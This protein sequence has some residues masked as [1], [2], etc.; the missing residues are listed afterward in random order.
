M[1]D[2]E[3]EVDG[4]SDERDVRGIKAAYSRGFKEG[5]RRGNE[6]FAL[7]ILVIAFAIFAF[8]LVNV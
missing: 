3:H 6:A 5:S 2:E 7:V 8:I 1:V 4:N